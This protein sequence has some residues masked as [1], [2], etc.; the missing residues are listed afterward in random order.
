M[1]QTKFESKK[2]TNYYK[3]ARKNEKK[4][5]RFRNLITTMTIH[6]I[7]RGGGLVIVS[8]WIF[9]PNIVS[10]HRWCTSHIHVHVVQ[11]VLN[12]KIAQF[13]TCP[14]NC[15]QR[16]NQWGTGTKGT[17]GKHCT[18]ACRCMLHKCATML[19]CRCWWGRGVQINGCCLAPKNCLPRQQIR[20][21][22]SALSSQLPPFLT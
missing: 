8:I 3:Q 14:D 21:L 17:W 22:S 20:S 1:E 13:C 10:R 16:V 5:N 9:R 19:H 12:G 15:C 4:N 18:Y 2:T 7:T 11:T 6:Q